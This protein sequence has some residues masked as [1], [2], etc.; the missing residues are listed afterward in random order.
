[1]TDSDGASIPKAPILYLVRD[2]S[3]VSLAG[4]IATGRA[5]G[6]TWIVASLDSLQDSTQLTVT[7]ARTMLPGPGFGVGA[8]AT[9]VLYA[10]GGP[11]RLLRIDP[12]SHAVVA[13]INLPGLPGLVAFNNAG[14]RAFVADRLGHGI[15]VID[16]TNDHLAGSI[17]TLTGDSLVTALLVPDGDSLLAVL[18]TNNVYVIRLSTGTI[19]Q[20]L[21]LFFSASGLASHGTTLYVSYLDGFYNNPAASVL[22]FSLPALQQLSAYFTNTSTATGM[23][24]TPNAQG[25]EVTN[26]VTIYS[27]AVNAANYSVL[28]TVALPNY[29]SA[30]SIL[31]SPYSNLLVV[32]GAGS[33]GSLTPLGTSKRVFSLGGTTHQMAAL[34]NGEVAIAN[35][36]GWV[37]FIK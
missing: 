22:S 17:A 10:S 1:M 4:G 26:G 7:Q 37:D 5:Q 29:A 35:A 8:S 6:S 28:T 12:A 18:G 16:A 31:H 21:P 23:T 24:L 25:I 20:V 3:V 36:G 14:T 15:S 32:S 13:S 27:Q 2:S 34:K 19:A 9:G 30:L 11:N 33:A